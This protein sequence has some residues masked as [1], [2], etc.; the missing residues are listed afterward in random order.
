MTDELASIKMYSDYVKKHKGTETV[1]I[2]EQLLNDEKKHLGDWDEIYKNITGKSFVPNK[3]GEP[4]YRFTTDDLEV[5]VTAHKAENAAYNFYKNAVGKAEIIDG[6]HAFQH[7]A[8]EEKIHVEKL[9]NEYF[10]L[11][12]EKLQ[13]ENQDKGHII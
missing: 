6:S 7:M 4:D 12:N 2:F 10:R 8:W 5:I 9:E 13:I 11:V 1:N 3:P